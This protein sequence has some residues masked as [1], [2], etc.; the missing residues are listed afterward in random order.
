[1]HVFVLATLALATIPR[2]DAPPLR[3]RVV[4][5]T[6]LTVDHVIVGRGRCGGSTWL[7][8]DAPALIE[9][10]APRLGNGEW[11]TS[12][13]VVRGFGRDERS[14][15]LA[16]VG[17]RQLWTLV[18]YRTLARL[19]TS[20]EVMS[21]LQL[22][23]PHLNVFGAG[24]LLLLQRPPTAV[25]AALLLS[26]QVADVNRAH[27]WPALT[28][29]AQAVKQTDVASGL[30]ACGIG[31]GASLPCWIA[32]DTR[33]VVS[34]GTPERT[35][36]VTP[37]FLTTTVV[38]ST[39][40]L[41]DAATTSSSVLWILTS[42]IGAEAGRR[43]GARLTRSDLRGQLVASVDLQPR[44]RLILSANERMALV[45]TTDGTLVEVTVP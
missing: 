19:S 33:I 6:A 24:E 15:G 43:V 22:R 10:K 44:A 20:G 13:I 38:D 4:S 12:T 8:T 31:E 3:Q 9:V 45:L 14:W 17:D 32:T 42:A 7:L 2:P 37:R 34:D 35:T 25:G 23:Q 1:M 16:C 18:G 36:V 30:V 11:V 5:I 29:P 27:P 21:R 39:T 26:A 28:A 41:W 40:P